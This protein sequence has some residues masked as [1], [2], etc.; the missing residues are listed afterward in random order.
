MLKATLLKSPSVELNGQLLTFPYRRAEALLYYMFV[1]HSATRQEL[2]AL[3]WESYDDV[4]GLKNLRN[5]LYTLKKVLG[6]EFLISPQK[7]LVII[8]PD[9]EY[10]CDYDRFI[11]DGDF[12]A[13][14][15]PFLQGFSVKH[16]FSYEEWL[17]RTRDKLH[18]QYLHKISDQAQACLKCGNRKQA[19][20]WAEESLREEPLDETMCAFL[21]NLQR[22]EKQ[23]VRATQI[24][25]DLKKRLSEEL[26]TEPMEATTV[27]YYEIMNEWN[28]TT[29]PPEHSSSAPVLV[30]RE[31]IYAQLRA[32]LDSF[33]LEAARHC[34][35]LL[36]G[37]VGSGKGE[38]I[39]YLLQSIDLSSFLVIRCACLQSEKL[40]P[41]APWD[42]VML[43]LA[44][45][46]QRE[47][48]SLSEPIR[49]RLGQVF[50]VFREGGEAGATRLLRKLDEPLKDSLMM[51]LE[52]LTRRHK[53]LLILENLQWM[54]PDSLSLMDTVMRH[55]GTGGLMMILTCSGGGSPSLQKSLRCDAADN[56]LQ[57][58]SLLPFTR[59]Q[60]DT[61]LQ[62]ELGKKTAL[63]L[64]SC[65]YDETGGNFSL[66]MELTR[67]FLRNGS[68]KE[69][70]NSL[71]DILM[72]CL[73]GLDENTIHIAELISV[74]QQDAPCEILLELLS[75]NETA[76]SSGLEELLH[77]HLIEEYR[78]GS[79]I[80]YRFFHERIR[81][82]I[83]DRLN[84]FQ[85]SPLHLRIAQLFTGDG[86]PV[87][88]DICRRAARHFH[89]GG[90][91]VRSLS[92]RI[93]ALDLESTRSCEPFPCVPCEK[94]A[95]VPSEKLQEELLQCEQELSDLQQSAQGTSTLPTLENQ[96]ILIRGRL[97]L[98]HGDFEKGSAVL[99]T[100]SATGSEDR[101]HNVIMI[102]ACYLLASCALYR[103]SLSLAERYTAAGTRLLQKSGDSVLSAQFQRLRGACFCLRGDY[104]KSGYYFL[105][106]IEKLEKQLPSTAARI[107]L[108]AANSAC[109]RLFRQRQDYANACSYFKKALDTLDGSEKGSWPG[110]VWVYI[111]YGRTTFFMEDH[112]RA[113]QLFLRGY[114]LSQVTGELWGRTAAA[115]FTS[116][117]QI[118]D[119]NFEAAINSLKDAQKSNI[120]QQ[121][122]LEGAILCF[123]SMAIR[124][125]LER[126]QQHN[127]ELDTLLTFSS[128]SYARQGL[129]LLSGIPDVAEAQLL[130]KSLRDGITDQQH[131]HA[132]ELYSKNKHFMTE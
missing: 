86:L 50:S 53:I 90:D 107:Q 73:S 89:L 97:L 65:F 4:T 41:L 115:A 62:N 37:D 21:M 40:M 43:P 61:L 92:C 117:Y 23:Y 102:R 120:R 59:E 66:L 46:I 128:A 118:Q 132:S 22:Q 54:D 106:A 36:M 60:T 26:G 58:H 127:R 116:Y 131:F 84:Y 109:G 87:Q 94:I 13:Y 57:E 114:E 96:L 32:A 12:S 10:T 8:N 17:S 82:L 112:L 52:M 105:E 78:D 63:Q 101:N 44:E 100:L 108:A 55:L 5:A 103:Q 7:S 31:N 119:G 48:L 122:P 99:G 34:S 27:L 49:A 85:R 45:L 129:R 15:G 30:G 39:D 64:Q 67:A 68:T 70:L 72:E 6:G 20:C 123:V 38:M 111:H 80:T 77:R 16:S 74:F 124:Q 130:S 95:F 69:T 76:L 1:Q 18:E 71:D 19:I 125:Y 121:S 91:S 9:W 104:D 113:Q 47:S 98:F 24:Y 75:G 83:Y 79:E 3:L 88:S 28:D 29:F 35:Q 11:Q 25:Q 56:L 110:A 33:R 81:K 2:I 14:A 126:T 51:L 93:R 42:R